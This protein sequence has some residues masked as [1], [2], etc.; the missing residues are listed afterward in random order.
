MPKPIQTLLWHSY[1]NRRSRT[2]ATFLEGTSLY[3]RDC[4]HARKRAHQ[5]M[6]RTKNR[7]LTQER[8]TTRSYHEDPLDDG[9]NCGD[10]RSTTRE[11]QPATR[12][13][14][15]ERKKSQEEIMA[16]SSPPPLLPFQRQSLYGPYQP[17]TVIHNH[18][19]QESEKRCKT[20][21]S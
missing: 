1:C 6:K 10:C 9:G 16:T 2:T 7:I 3:A 15:A 21:K 18:R 12:L 4:S 5:N 13:P 11:Y 17:Q 20:H 19:A 14:T 8:M